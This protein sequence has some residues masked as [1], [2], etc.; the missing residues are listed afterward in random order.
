MPGDRFPSKDEDRKTADLAWSAVGYLLAGL[1]FYGGLGWVIGTWLG[2]REAFTA[3]GALVGICL[4]L[5]LTY[6]RISQPSSRR[7]PK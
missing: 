2:N 5:Y 7:N 6:V 1:L 3:F 4:S